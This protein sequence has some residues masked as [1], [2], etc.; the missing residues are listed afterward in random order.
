[1]KEKHRERLVEWLKSQGLTD[2]QIMECLEY[3]SK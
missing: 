3:I 1:M 2:E